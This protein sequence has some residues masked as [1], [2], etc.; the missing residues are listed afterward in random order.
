MRQLR[1]QLETQLVQLKAHPLI[2]QLQHLAQQ[3][4]LLLPL[5]QVQ[6]NKRV[7]VLGE[8]AKVGTT[9]LLTLI[10]RSSGVLSG[11]WIAGGIYEGAQKRVIIGG[12]ADERGTREY[13]LALGER[14]AVICT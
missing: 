3:A 5:L 9:V 11:F 12:H 8:F 14:R 6:G 13:N 1:Q 7:Q 10:Q 2:P 4:L